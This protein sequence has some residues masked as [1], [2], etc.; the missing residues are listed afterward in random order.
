TREETPV[1]RLYIAA[2]AISL[3]VAVRDQWRRR[4][5]GRRQRRLLPLPR[6]A[7]RPRHDSHPTHTHPPLPRP[8]QRQGRTPPL[9]AQR[10]SLLPALP[11]RAPAACHPRRIPAI[12]QPLPTRRSPHLWIHALAVCGRCSA[13]RA[14]FAPSTPPMCRHAPIVVLSRSSREIRRQRAP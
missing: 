6:L 8:D 2:K 5:R 9:P 13:D 12:I 11:L 4:D 3:G 14:D 1:E 10:M 7:R